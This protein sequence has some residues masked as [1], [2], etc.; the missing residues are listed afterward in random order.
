MHLLYEV[1]HGAQMDGELGHHG[2]DGVHVE[3]VRQ[4]SLLGQRRQGLRPINKVSKRLS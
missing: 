2:K 4:W 3:D 1:D